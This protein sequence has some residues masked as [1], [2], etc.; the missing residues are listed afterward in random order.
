[1]ASRFEEAPSQVVNKVKEVIRDKFPV[2][3][4]CNIEVVMDL[5]KRKS[6]GTYTLVKLDKASPILRHI[7]ADNTNPEGVD[8]ILY[9]DKTV[10]DEMIDR[11]KVR[12]IS[13]G[14]HHADCDFEKEMPYGVRKPTVQTFYEEISENADDDRWSE[15][16]DL[17]A[18]S[19]YDRDESTNG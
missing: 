19:I 17:M 3:N 8:Y 6:G 2:L 9:L 5:K 18:E 7:S 13:H 4:G 1:M 14:L 11:D 15:R 12:I 10:Y 16:L